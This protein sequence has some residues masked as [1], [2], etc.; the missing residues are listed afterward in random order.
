MNNYTQRNVYIRNNYSFGDFS[1]YVYV[2]FP[3]VFYLVT[4][5]RLPSANPYV[6]LEGVF[7]PVEPRVDFSLLLSL[8][9]AR[10][11]FTLKHSNIYTR[12]HVLT[13]KRKQ[14][15]THACTNANSNSYTSESSTDIFAVFYVQI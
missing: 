11:V 1:G 4:C 2:A 3:S 9:L 12:K 14:S 13:G 10:T 8:S 5:R 7:A 6:L 15:H